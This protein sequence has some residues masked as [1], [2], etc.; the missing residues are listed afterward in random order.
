VYSVHFVVLQGVV[1]R[2]G[3]FCWTDSVVL[4]LSVLSRNYTGR[5]VRV[6]H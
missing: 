5:V 6:R 4:G 1:V 2:L 3:A